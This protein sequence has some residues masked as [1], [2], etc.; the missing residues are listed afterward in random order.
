MF[1]LLGLR[2]R[3]SQKAPE[4]G[5]DWTVP[6]LPET[7]AWPEAD[8]TLECSVTPLWPSTEPPA[9]LAVGWFATEDADPSGP[10]IAEGRLATLPHDAVRRPFTLPLGAIAQ[11]VPSRPATIWVDL[12]QEMAF[13]FQH[14]GGVPLR[15]DLERPGRDFQDWVRLA[16]PRPL[17]ELLWSAR[18]LNLSGPLA[19]ARERAALVPPLAAPAEHAP[20][21]RPSPIAALRAA[22]DPVAALVR[23]A[24]GSA[25]LGQQPGGQEVGHRMAAVMAGTARWEN[26]PGRDNPYFQ[27]VRLR[28]P[29]TNAPLTAAIQDALSCVPA[30]LLPELLESRDELRRWWLFDV[31]LPRGLPLSAL[32]REDLHWWQQPVED[33]GRLPVSRFAMARDRERR[34]ISRDEEP[35]QDDDAGRLALLFRHVLHDGHDTHA[36]ALTGRDSLGVLQSELTVDGQSV[37]LFQALVALADSPGGTGFAA[38]HGGFGLSLRQA[39]RLIAEELPPLSVLLPEVPS[40]PVPLTVVGHYNSSGV[41]ENFRMMANSL[42]RSGIAT[43]M[44]DAGG[45]AVALDGRETLVSLTQ[46]P[47]EEVGAL[48]YPREATTLFMIN[49]ENIGLVAANPAF[50]ATMARR[51]VGFFLSEAQSLMPAQVAVCDTMDEIWTPSSFVRDIYAAHTARPVRCVGKALQWPDTTPDPYHRFMPGRRNRFVFLTSF[52]PNSW[53][54]RK[55]PTAVVAAFMQAFPPQEKDV[56]LVVKV[57]GLPRNHPGDPYG[58]W[59]LIEEAVARD[60]RII[61]R[62]EYASFLDYLGYIAHADCVVSAHRSEGFGYLCAQAHHYRTPLIAT[63]YSGNMDFCT[64]ENTWLIEHDMVPVGEGEFLPGT[65]GDWADVRVPHLAQLMRDAASQRER[66]IAMARAG[67]D[68]VQKLYA[69]EHFD[70]VIKE[71]LQA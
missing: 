24:G 50:G 46:R 21:P 44:F 12:L 4:F 39:A 18:W 7:A 19:A 37:T 9:E 8:L 69:P 64:P 55:N 35:R 62:E 63:G 36:M 22:E 28:H 67:R 30:R 15:F 52:D 23:L 32:P 53:L 59:A 38:A 25:P 49:P 48:A 13:W 66:A 29:G 34:L 61:L 56:A 20:Q 65:R 16:Q 27:H 57:P 2:G 3:Q 51:R 71:L 60:P 68:M 45:Q 1:R 58:E 11:S 40:L 10:R 43:R 54:R 17:A 14:R 47:R 5:C 42:D 6:A 33:A 41:G 70:R 26:I 31:V